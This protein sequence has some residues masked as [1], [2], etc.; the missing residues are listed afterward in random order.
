MQEA[1]KEFL[2]AKKMRKTH[3]NGGGNGYGEGEVC[4][5]T[6]E[7]SK[8]VY[9]PTGWRECSVVVVYGDVCLKCKKWKV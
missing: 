4:W 8:S 7:Q 6:S 2:G 5:Y 3:T 1:P 9:V